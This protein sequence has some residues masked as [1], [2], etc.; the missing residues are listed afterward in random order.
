MPV[1]LVRDQA[2]ENTPMRDTRVQTAEHPPG[3]EKLWLQTIMT[4]NDNC[5]EAI[6]GRLR[7]GINGLGLGSCPSN[8]GDLLSQFIQELAITIV[9]G[10]KF[11][12]T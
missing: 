2:T 6:V 7:S 10:L 8:D 5:Q 4:M 3:G 9:Y 12:A 11:G 1:R